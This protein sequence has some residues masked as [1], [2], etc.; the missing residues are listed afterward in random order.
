M[1]SGGAGSLSLGPQAFP[2]TLLPPPEGFGTSLIPVPLLW[3]G[4]SWAWGWLLAAGSSTSQERSALW[5]VAFS[6]TRRGTRAFVCHPTHTLMGADDSLNH[7]RKFF[8][9]NGLRV[10]LVLAL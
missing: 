4:L 9:V 10:N 8:H 1:R 6:Q 7:T 2:C 5:V 3:E